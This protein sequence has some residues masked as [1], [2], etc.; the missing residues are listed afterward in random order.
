M[1]DEGRPA[2]R[3]LPRYQG[4]A[5]RPPHDDASR[6]V[7][8]VSEQV[9]ATEA[10]AVLPSPGDDARVA[11]TRLR[12]AA[13]GVDLLVAGVVPVVL[14]S[15]G[16]LRVP[17][18]PI[19]WWLVLVLVTTLG[20]AATGGLSTWLTGGQTIGKALT[21]LSTRPVGA[22]SPRTDLVGLAWSLGRHSFG[23]LVVDVVLVGALVSLVSP[24]RRWLHDVAF[25]S[26]VVH[27][28]PPAPDTLE[29]RARGF[30]ARMQSGLD[31]SREDYGWLSFLWRWWVRVV[32][33]VAGVV[34]VAARH[35]SLSSAT[36]VTTPAVASTAAPTAT[37]PLAVT[38]VV[39]PT[40]A[41]TAL[42]LGATLNSS[43]QWE[44]LA[45]TGSLEVEDGRGLAWDPT[46]HGLV[47]RLK[48]GVTFVDTE[49]LDVTGTIDVPG[50]DD[51]AVDPDGAR[52]WLT[53]RGP[54]PGTM[55]VL[56]IDTGR[57]R[58]VGRVSGEFRASAVEVVGAGGEAVVVT[59]RGDL[60]TVDAEEVRVVSQ[61]RVTL[62]EPRIQ[63]DAQNLAYDRDRGRL[64]V[65][66]EHDLAYGYVSVVDAT[67]G[68]ETAQIGSRLNG[69]GLAVDPGTGAVFFP[70][71]AE[72]GSVFSRDRRQ[73]FVGVVDGVDASATTLPVE[74]GFGPE[75]L[76][77][78]PDAGIVYAAD[79]EHDRVTAVDAR[80]HGVLGTVEVPGPAA[81]AVDP[82]D[83]R[84]FAIGRDPDS[85]ARTLYVLEPR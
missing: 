44:G 54:T 36:E 25:G 32:V 59:D 72:S 75:A 51:L 63:H 79:E 40:T 30:S 73:P 56:V 65:L 80:T 13:A 38:A 66:V 77:V 22:P 64:Y 5:G 28:P 50:T 8:L 21:H 31:R 3:H 9:R 4:G 41:V 18:P 43:P 57:Q 45:L 42:G 83:G 10:D 68:S 70:H 58:L 17:D 55:S 49:P 53:A 7:V 20:L 33:A 16:T 84:V 67:T 47:V 52:A 78:D 26:Q 19:P 85:S 48:N 23:Y 37:G 12:L 29:G 11:P 1:A 39:V 15:V 27:L 6:G 46:T 71:G 2:R 60:L 74:V 34:Y 35:L 24:R 14:V 69:P 82:E 62:R 76:A 61:S 81:L